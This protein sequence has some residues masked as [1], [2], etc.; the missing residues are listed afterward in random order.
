MVEGVFEV[1]FFVFFFLCIAFRMKGYAQQ[2]NE[3]K[4]D[5]FQGDNEYAAENYSYCANLL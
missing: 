4:E 2:A 3:R 5:F 1:E